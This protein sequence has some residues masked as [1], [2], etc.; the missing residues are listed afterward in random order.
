MKFDFANLPI[1]LDKRLTDCLLEAS[2]GHLITYIPAQ[3][4]FWL[5]DDNQ[6]VEQGYCLVIERIDETDLKVTALVHF[7]YL[8]EEAK[9][10]GVW[11][12]H[13]NGATTYHHRHDVDATEYFNQW[14]NA[15]LTE[16]KAND[17]QIQGSPEVFPI[18]SVIVDIVKHGRQ[19]ITEN[20]Y[21]LSALDVVMLYEPI[22]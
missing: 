9:L 5:D 10:F 22:P 19:A 11:R 17:A 18:A 21:S 13:R 12:S 15:C 8:N 1:T 4:T 6:N 2:E 14:Q 20:R 7:E 16:L 3:M